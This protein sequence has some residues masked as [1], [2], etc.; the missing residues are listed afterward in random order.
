[1]VEQAREEAEIF[2]REAEKNLDVA[3]RR[4]SRAMEEKIA[5]AEA[6]AVKEVKA[7]AVEAAVGAAGSVLQKNLKAGK[8][9]KLVDKAIKDLGK[10]LN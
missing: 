6:K 7:A 2:A 8:H 1:M 5:Q 4:Q 3:F 10:R 9:K